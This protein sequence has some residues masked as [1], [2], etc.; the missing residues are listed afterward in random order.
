MGTLD[1]M[2]PE[3]KRDAKN[4]DRRADVYSVGVMLY[5]MSTGR[6]P[7][8]IFDPPSRINKDIPKDFDVIVMKCLRDK[9]A[10]RYQTCQELSNAL[11]TLPQN[12]STMVRMITSVKS[13]VTNI[14]TQ[15][16][17]RNP[18]Y[19]AAV[20][21]LVAGLGVGSVAVWKKDWLK[22]N[23]NGNTSGN[24]NTG[25]NG[26]G[27]TGGNGNG[28]S[29][30]PPD[31]TAAQAAE[32]ALAKK[33]KEA[34]D[35]ADKGDIKAAIDAYA[36]LLPDATGALRQEI[37]DALRDLKEHQEIALAEEFRKKLDEAR[38]DPELATAASV[39]AL[40]K[41][42]DDANAQKVREAVVF[43]ITT[44]LERT[45]NASKVN[46]QA[47]AAR[48]RAANFRE[49]ADKAKTSIDAGDLDAAE[50]ALGLVANLAEG[51]SETEEYGRL[52]RSLEAKRGAVA[53]AEESRRR[54][55]KFMA[56]AGEAAS[57]GDFTPA[58]LR[59]A[60]AE[61][62]ATVVGGDA[63]NLV[64]A[65][66]EDIDRREKN[67]R[68]S[69]A[70]LE[71]KKLETSNPAAAAAG[72]RAAADIAPSQEEAASANT[73]AK[74]LEDNAA[75]EASD[76]LFNEHLEAARKAKETRDWKKVE[77][78]ARAALE[79]RRNNPEALALQAEAVKAMQEKPPDP[80][81]LAFTFK[82]SFKAGKG[83]LDSV[84]LDPSGV[85]YAL[86]HWK[87]G[88]KLYTVAKDLSILRETAIPLSYPDRV[89][90]DSK[91]RIWISE[92][93]NLST[94]N[95]FDATNGTMT[96]SMAGKGSADGKF[97]YLVDIA[98]S[99]DGERMYGLDSGNFR[100]QA[101]ATADGAFQWKTGTK[102]SGR[103]M[104]DNHFYT[105]RN[106]AVD[107]EGRIYT[108]DATTKTI[109]RFKPDGTFDGIFKSFT[110][111]APGPIAW[112]NKRLYVMDVKQN[113]LIVYAPDGTEL[114]S[115]PMYGNGDSQVAATTAM[116]V[117]P[118][119]KVYIADRGAKIVVL[120]EA[121]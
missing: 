91:G 110:D 116:V 11:L 51:A 31:E 74:I 62:L 94:I 28:T 97:N 66:R 35:L 1:Y 43:Q 5:E 30:K 20:L 73:K 104:P 69:Q 109:Q 24:G 33:I 114:G 120:E 70:I 23:P 87:G 82:G 72:Y 10:E 50:K 78:E 3:Q 92:W 17:R 89:Y 79:V 9:P 61:A 26:N 25:N 40:Q 19:I 14:G 106:L 16:G 118:D 119:G 21:F 108:S 36:L 44:E 46:E 4:V 53:T 60:D 96:R 27:N 52:A 98:V 111:G 15:I 65:A 88:G 48:T 77:A 121:K 113:K 90:V 64:K 37:N 103:G 39:A 86:D 22:P 80:K 58:R 100:L 29:T 117:G 84:A 47:A 34:G 75:R 63:S 57:R 7:M 83:G 12:P 67:A 8:G 32:K 101:L 71:A 85:F 54:F 13:G 6:V 42:L 2:A 41:L 68:Y 95:L 55:D 112:A 59:L 81:R 49:A 93:G 115:N 38:V 45:R 105:A 56:E 102:W 99:P 18:R 107:P 76:R